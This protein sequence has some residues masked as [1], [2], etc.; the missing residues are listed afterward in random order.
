VDDAVEIFA[1]AAVVDIVIRVDA[2]QADGEAV[3]AVVGFGPPAVELERGAI[4][5][6]GLTCWRVIFSAASDSRS[7]VAL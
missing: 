6:F 3:E 1:V 2:A 7:S 5:H 4:L